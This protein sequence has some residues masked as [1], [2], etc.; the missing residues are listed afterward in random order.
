MSRVTNQAVYLLYNISEK[1]ATQ[2][3]V[4][5]FE[6]DQ[7]SGRSSSRTMNMLISLDK[8]NAA[9]QREEFHGII[10]NNNYCNLPFSH[11]IIMVMISDEHMLYNRTLNC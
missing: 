1:F 8:S 2:E 3:K 7:Q 5:S 6:S 10:C 4:A 11:I 9:Q